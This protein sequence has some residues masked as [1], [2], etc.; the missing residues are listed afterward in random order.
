[1]SIWESRHHLDANK[2]EQA[3]FYWLFDRGGTISAG[4]FQRRLVDFL[5]M[6]EHYIGYWLVF[7]F[8]N[9]SLPGVLVI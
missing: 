6:D 8:I 9:H 4:Y 3:S 5:N 7:H 2:G 1:M